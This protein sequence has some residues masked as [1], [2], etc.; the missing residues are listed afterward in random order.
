MKDLRS[1]LAQKLQIEIKN[2]LVDMKMVTVSF[3]GNVTI[4][5]NET[6]TVLSIVS[7]QSV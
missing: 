3:P 5:V 2:L 6:V 7:Y 1:C 4:P